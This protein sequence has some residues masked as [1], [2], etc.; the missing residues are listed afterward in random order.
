MIIRI[1]GIIR[2]RVFFEE[3]RYVYSNVC[4]AEKRTKRSIILLLLLVRFSA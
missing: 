3:I 4:H 1:A 2:G